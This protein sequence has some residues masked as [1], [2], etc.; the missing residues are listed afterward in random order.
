M[1]ILHIDLWKLYIT[2]IRETKSSLPNYRCIERLLRQPP[3]LS[4]CRK[5]TNSFLVFVET[6]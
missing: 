3:M 5:V 6:N 4:M 2:Y 1:D